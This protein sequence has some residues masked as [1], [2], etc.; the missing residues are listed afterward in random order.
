MLDHDVVGGQ[1][2]AALGVHVPQAGH[3]PVALAPHVLEGQVRH[4]IDAALVERLHELRRVGGPQLHRRH[5]VGHHEGR[6]RAPGTR[7]LGLVLAVLV[8]DQNIAGERR[9]PGQDVPAAGDEIR[10]LAEEA[11]IGRA[12]GRDDDDVR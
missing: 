11:G 4:E 3:Q 8:V 2:L 12:A 5:P 6:R 9:L 10:T 7:T 1:L